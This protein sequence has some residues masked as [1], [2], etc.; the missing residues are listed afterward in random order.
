M[1]LT[2]ADENAMAKHELE[3]IIAQCGVQSKSPFAML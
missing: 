2:L 1:N 3:E